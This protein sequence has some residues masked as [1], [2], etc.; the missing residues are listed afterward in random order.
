MTYYSTELY[1]H[2][3]KGMKWGVR[4]F[5][6]EDGT[7]TA[8]GKKREASQ[9]DK[10]TAR[11][12]KSAYRA[13]VKSARKARRS[14]DS[15]IQK[16]YDTKLNRIERKYK[17][18]QDISEKDMAK[19]SELDA[20]ARKSWDESKNTYKQE[21][22]A[23]K[24]EYKKSMAELKNTEEYKKANA[25][26]KAL[27]VGAAVAVTAAAA[28]GGYKLSEKKFNEYSKKSQEATKFIV[29]NAPKLSELESKRG[30][31][32][33]YAHRMKT[34]KDNNNA[35][36]NERFSDLSNEYI[37]KYMSSKKK[38]PFSAMKVVDEI[39]S[40]N[41]YRSY[42]SKAK[43]ANYYQQKYESKAAELSK[44]AYDLKNKIQSAHGTIK[45]NDEAAKKTAYYKIQQ[46][47]YKHQVKKKKH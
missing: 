42:Q 22:A 45:G 31:A 23:A 19:A 18:G 5:Q 38:A 10:T 11:S 8:L 26:K 6:N 32:I 16:D 24:A 4:R 25:R 15:E 44:D 33:D 29:D 9:G 43:K 20:S 47:K 28:Y 30:K 1:H 46:M 40:D 13:S 36:A 17:A 21:K 35:K 14:R 7:R 3:I 37:N 2:G 27:L 12:L 41:K 34:I 39:D